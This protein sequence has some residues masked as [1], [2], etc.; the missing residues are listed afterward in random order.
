M[1]TDISHIGNIKN[2]GTTYSH[3][4]LKQEQFKN[5]LQGRGGVSCGIQ[6]QLTPMRVS[7]RNIPRN[8]G[9]TYSHAGLGILKNTII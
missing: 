6:E 7:A 3:A 5:K 1:K 4:I 8:T 2:S 9:T